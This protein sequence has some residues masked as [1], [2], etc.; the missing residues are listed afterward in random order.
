MKRVW[1]DCLGSTVD[2]IESVKAEE[3]AGYGM[4]ECPERDC[5]EGKVWAAPRLENGIVVRDGYTE[6]PTC[7]GTG[8]AKL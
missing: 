1:F 7:R 5:E 8:K 2:F 6:C 4:R 3:K